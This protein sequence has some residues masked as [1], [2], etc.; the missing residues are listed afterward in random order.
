MAKVT[1][2]NGR[3]DTPLPMRCPTSYLRNTCLSIS[4]DTGAKKRGRD[5][6]RDAKMLS[7]RLCESVQAG[8]R[9]VELGKRV[10]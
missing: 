5:E 9:P 8:S 10:W 3:R 7:A 4:S 1:G 2:A 6:R